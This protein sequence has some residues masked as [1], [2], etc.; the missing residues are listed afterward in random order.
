MISQEQINNVVD[1]IV[2]NVHPDQV[3]L[4]GSYAAGSPSPDSDLDILVVKDMNLPSHQRSPQIKK[5]LRGLK[6][7][8]D[9]VVCTKGELEKWRGIKSTFANEILKRGRVVYG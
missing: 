8:I 4:F 3:I 2:K 9:L 7:P 5:Y 1:I 6:I